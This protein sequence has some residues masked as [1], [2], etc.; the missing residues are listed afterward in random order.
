MKTLDQAI[1]Q[2]PTS[3]EGYIMRGAAYQARDNVAKALAD[4][5]KAIQLDR[6]SARVYCDRAALEEELLH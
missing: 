5:N 3:A 1:Q 2:E 6:K 4:F